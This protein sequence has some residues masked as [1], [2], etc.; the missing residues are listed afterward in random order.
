[1]E[2]PPQDREPDERM[3]RVVGEGRK[4]LVLYDGDL[5]AWILCWN[6]TGVDTY[7]LFVY[8]TSKI[9]RAST[10]INSLDRTA[11]GGASCT[12][13]CGLLSTQILYDNVSV[14]LLHLQRTAVLLGIDKSVDIR[15]IATVKEAGH[16]EYIK[17]DIPLRPFEYTLS[18]CLEVLVFR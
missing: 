2:R 4:I 5:S 11:G 1:M 8:F 16:M 9:M 3:Y 18:N 10:Y 17:R 13:M 15:R 12:A 14:L 7:H 6:Q